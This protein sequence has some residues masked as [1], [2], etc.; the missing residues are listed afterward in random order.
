MAHSRGGCTNGEPEAVVCRV[1]ELGNDELDRPV[2]AAVGGEDTSLL[3][4]GLVAIGRPHAPGHLEAEAGRRRLLVQRELRRHT[5]PQDDR[6]WARVT[7]GD[8]VVKGGYV[9]SG[10]DRREQL[11]DGESAH[12]L[13]PPQTVPTGRKLRDL[14]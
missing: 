11:Q 10:C 1:S 3:R 5:R 7:R 9:L 8:P 2:A 6:V 12:A 13:E 4:R 14:T